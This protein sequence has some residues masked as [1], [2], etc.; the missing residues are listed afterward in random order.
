MSPEALFDFDEM[1]DWRILKEGGYLSLREPKVNFF[2]SHP[3]ES[4]KHPDPIARQWNSLKRLF[5]NILVPVNPSNPRSTGLSANYWFM[6]QSF[7]RYLLNVESYF[8][9]DKGQNET[10]YR[11]Y[12]AIR[13][14]SG[15]SYYYFDDYIKN[16]EKLTEK[17]RNRFRKNIGIW[18]DYCCLPQGKRTEE[19][20]SYFDQMLS[21]ICYL[22]ASCVVVVVWPDEDQQRKRAWCLVEVAINRVSTKTGAV[23]PIDRLFYGNSEIIDN[24]RGEIVLF[25]DLSENTRS[26][27]FNLI[28]IAKKSNNSSCILEWLAK[29]Q[30]NCTYKEDLEVVA[31]AI[32]ATVA[33][34]RRIGLGLSFL[35]ICSNIIETIWWIYSLPVVLTFPLHPITLNIADKI[36]DLLDNPNYRKSTK[37]FFGFLFFIFALIWGILT[38]LSFA[39]LMPLFPLEILRKRIN[40]RILKSIG[41]FVIKSVAPNK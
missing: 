41:I 8:G 35:N 15:D 12:N 36:F 21:Q 11:A 31:T 22:A 40:F 27:L 33:P 1:P 5:Y 28:Y 20:K 23:R 26:Y 25:S 18:I 39:F 2:I 37:I 19:E 7:N 13:R 29:N 32:Y 14:I 34:L 16:K 10:I 6:P 4:R 30:V 17:R 38:I 3:W 9:L 24:E